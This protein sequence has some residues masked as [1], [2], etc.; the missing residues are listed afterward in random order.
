MEG[1][2]GDSELNQ[3]VTDEDKIDECSKLTATK[4]TPLEIKTPEKVKEINYA[5][6]DGV[7]GI[8]AFSVF[9]NHLFR[10]YIGTR[11]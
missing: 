5:F 9:L 10:Q 1:G 4:F 11:A 7:R 2:K 8:G 6:L 3:I